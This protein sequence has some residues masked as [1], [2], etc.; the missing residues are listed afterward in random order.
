MKHLKIKPEDT[1]VD[2]RYQRE[3]DARRVEV[4]AN[5]FNPDL[6]GV[7][8]VSRRSDGSIVRIDGQHRIAANI[9]AGG[10][11]TPVLMEVHD[12]LSLQEEAALFIKLNGG[13][14]SIMAIDKF[15]ARLEARE[16]VALEIQTVLKQF[17]CKIVKSSQRG[18]IKCVEAIE[19]AYRHNALERVLRTLVTWLDGNSEAFEVRIVRALTDF[20]VAF[21]DANPMHLAKRLE[22]YPATR[23]DILL[24]REELQMGGR[25]SRRA[26]GEHVFFEIYNHN[27]PRAKRIARAA[28]GN[29]TATAAE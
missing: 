15:R 23:L 2:H 16:P 6:F 21:P 20:F 1:T 8:V 18:G 4:M 26:A 28:S 10:G 11:D 22:T 7:P 25:G 27:T 17:H 14:K 9:A 29:G 3:L 13:R 5:A 24:V 19:R 12:G